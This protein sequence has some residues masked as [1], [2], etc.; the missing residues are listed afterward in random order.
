MARRRE[1]PSDSR[2]YFEWLKNS[3]E[4]IYVA[5]L[6]VN[7]ERGRNT[8]AFHCQQAIEKALKAYLLLFS[9]KL[10]DGHNLT[11]LCRQALRFD[12]EFEQWFDESASLNRY[13]IETRY[14]ADIPIKLTKDGIKH[15]FGM[16]KSM[17]DFIELQVDEK[18]EEIFE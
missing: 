7:D 16:A 1:N 9:G 13:Y 6:L 4:D 2:L 11:W 15:V 17:Y 12:R 10:M 18:E 3:S 14:P 5:S 8:C